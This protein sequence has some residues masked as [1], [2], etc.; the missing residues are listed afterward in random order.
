MRAFVFSTITSTINML[1]DTHTLKAAYVLSDAVFVFGRIGV[2]VEYVSR[3]KKLSLKLK[4]NSLERHFIETKHT[5]GLNYILDIRATIKEFNKTKHPPKQLIVAYSAIERG[6]LTYFEEFLLNYAVA[7][8]QVGLS[9]MGTLLE[10]DIFHAFSIGKPS[11]A[12]IIE[13]MPDKE[14]AEGIL[15]LLYPSGNPEDEFILFVPVD[16]IINDFAPREVLLED[17]SEL[18]DESEDAPVS[19]GTVDSIRMTDFLKLT[20]LEYLSASELKALRNQLK[21]DGNECREMIGEY[22]KRNNEQRGTVLQRNRYMEDEF[23]IEVAKM[24]RKFDENTSIKFHPMNQQ[25]DAIT[26][27]LYIGEA[28]V[29]YYWKYFEEF[30]MFDEPTLKYAKEQAALNDKYQ[31]H[32]PFVCVTTSFTNQAWHEELLKKKEE[33]TRPPKLRKFIPVDD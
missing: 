15:D 29:E 30:K 33:D 14:L 23:T 17:T 12:V 3:A 1:D 4:L 13:G 31:P 22:I 10:K 8:D 26:Y 25:L 20:T 6:F 16:F 11:S 7:L 28:P 5:E 19:A 18:L 9:D 27:Q 21:E 2:L 24:Q 32:V